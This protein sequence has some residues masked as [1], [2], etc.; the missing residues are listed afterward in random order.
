VG[1]DGTEAPAFSH[2]SLTTVAVPMYEMGQQAFALLAE[3]MRNPRAKP[4]RVVLP[5]RLLMRESATRCRRP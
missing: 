1:F 4:Q 3:A 5:V 2:V